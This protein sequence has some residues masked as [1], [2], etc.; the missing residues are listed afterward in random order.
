LAPAN[1]TLRQPAVRVRQ[2]AQHSKKRK[3]KGESMAKKY[4]NS[5]TTD[6]KIETLRLDI[7]DT[8]DL[9]QSVDAE[10]QKIKSILATLTAKIEVLA[11]RVFE[12]E[13]TMKKKK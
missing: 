12:F 7:N 3:E 5:M 9:A 11:V 10:Q 13:Q 1:T 6:Q 2:A 4:W 8:L